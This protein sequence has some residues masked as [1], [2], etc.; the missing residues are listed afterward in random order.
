MHAPRSSLAV[1]VA[2][3]IFLV[4]PAVAEDHSDYVEGPFETGPEV[5]ETCLMCHEDD[6][7]EVMDTTHWTWSSTQ[8]WEGSGG[9]QQRGKANTFNNFCIAVSSNWPRCTSC[10]AGY[11]WK[12]ASFDFG[13]PTGVDCLVCHDRTGTYRKAPAGAG[14]P[15]DDVD[16]LAV[17]RSVGGPPTLQNCGACHFYGGGGDHVKH[18]DLDSSLVGASREY[19]VH[20]STE[21]AGFLCQDCHVTDDHVVR[22]NAFAVSPGHSNPIGCV[23]C[24]DT[25]PHEGSYLNAHQRV[26]CQTCHIPAFAKGLPTKIHWDWSVAGQDL[27]PEPDQYGLPTYAKKKGRFTWAKNVR[28]TYAWY[29]GSAEVYSMGETVDPSQPVLLTS[30]SGSKDDPDSRIHPFKV[31]EGRQIYDSQR[32]VLVV[33]KLYGPDGY[34]ST[35]DWDRA[36]ELGMA[37]VDEPYSGEYG[38]VDTKMYWRL[39]HMVVPGELALQCRDCHGPGDHMDWQALGYGDDPIRLRRAEKRQQQEES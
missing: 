14:S 19:D 1:A 8:Q 28:P 13:V 12:D 25:E 6:A 21:G 10:H 26:A 39:N 37:S 32:D 15:A 36:A 5:T 7:A 20:M 9:A 31:H 11:G 18:G 24:H 34:W 3:L 2:L 30:P 23:D 29:G 4:A 16:L 33:P 38:F 22:G 17:A 27:P 35:F